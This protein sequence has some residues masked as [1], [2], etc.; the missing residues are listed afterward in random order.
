MTVDLNAKVATQ[1]DA[2]TA[3]VRGLMDNLAP[4]YDRMMDFNEKLLF[5]DGRA[6]VCSQAH[7]AVLEIAVG[8]GRNLP[9]YP[10]DARVTGIELSAAMLATA[11][12]RAASL[13]LAADLRQ[14]DAQAL[15]FPDNSFDAVVCT[16]ALCTIP[17]DRQ[18]VREARRV[19]RPGG[20][21]LLLEHVRSPNWLVR[22]GQRALNGYFV[23]KEGDHLLR[24]PLEHLKAEGFEIVRLERSKLGIVERVVARKPA[25]GS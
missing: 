17:D 12:A 21:F 9:Y 13:G 11:K 25:V 7:G 6:W 10:A 24:E 1:Q 8:T 4:N 23:R 16:I 15:D 18:A 14:G 19:L 2:E 22:L 20:L 5:S 3:R